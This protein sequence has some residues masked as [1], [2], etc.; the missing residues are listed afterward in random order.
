MPVMD[1]YQATKAI[2]IIEQEKGLSRTPII[3]FT[4][5]A[6]KEEKRFC[7][8]SGMDD[9]VTKPVKINDLS[10]CLQQWIQM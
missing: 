2:R 7:L 5:N 10:N 1:G 4:A 9:V 8:Q 3:A 6:A